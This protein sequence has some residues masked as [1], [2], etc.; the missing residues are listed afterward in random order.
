[1]EIN[2]NLKQLNRIINDLSVLTGLSMSVL[3]TDR[4]TLVST[5]SSN[6]FCSALQKNAVCKKNC[7]H[8]DNA[9]LDRC[10]KSRK[11]EY[12]ICYAG[13]CDSAMPI[14]K[15]DML[16]G[17]IIMGRIRSPLSPENTSADITQNSKTQELY[18]S[19]PFFEHKKL[20]SL[21]DLLSHILFDTSIEIKYDTFIDR[22]AEYIDSNLEKELTVSSL[23][24]ALHVSKNYL[25]NA[26]RSYFDTTINEYVHQR[27]LKKAEQLLV[28]TDLTVYYIAEAVGITNYAYFCRMFKKAHCVTP[29]QY[30]E[31]FTSKKK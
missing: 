26:F 7:H 21:Y 11:L 6:D 8:S 3:D 5:S 13:L 19:T 27:R 14:I 31:S 25:Y 12:H 15:N 30:R 24:S 20:E 17:Y 4:N 10:Q 29:T 22:I 9:L 28:Q 23:C 2:Y 16:A 1:M 18:L